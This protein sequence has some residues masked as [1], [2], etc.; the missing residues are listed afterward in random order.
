MDYRGN[1]RNGLTR[2]IQYYFIMIFYSTGQTNATPRA[3]KNIFFDYFL[4]Y[5]FHGVWDS[6]IM[7]SIRR[8]SLRCMFINLIF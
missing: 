6:A 5:P 2:P 4:I 1:Y 3:R 7:Q 8:E